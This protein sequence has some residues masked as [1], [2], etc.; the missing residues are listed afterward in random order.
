MKLSTGLINNLRLL[1]K[2]DSIPISRLRML[3][4]EFMS[5]GLL[6]VKAHGSHK[7]IY[8][9]DPAALKI[10]LVSTYPEL[11][12]L[13]YDENIIVGKVADRS[14]Q[15]A[16]TGDSKISRKRSCPG[17]PVN[18]C[19]PVNCMLNDRYITIY[20]PEGSFMFISDWHSFIVPKDVIIVGVENMESF[21]MVRKW[22]Y[23]VDEFNDN[24]PCSF[25]CVYRY[26]NQKDKDKNIGSRDLREW[27]K[28]IPNKYIHFG[29]F[30]LAGINI[31]LSEFYSELGERAQFLIPKDIEKRLAR[32]SG[33][34]YNDHNYPN[35]KSDNP[36][37]QAL[38]DLINKYH[39]GYDQE[40]YN[41]K[42]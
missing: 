1:I 2:G 9:P 5:E 32:G 24:Q 28:S 34:R 36:R 23:L 20:P 8:A 16:A 29:D 14:I 6:S 3:S 38:I 7:I 11:A 41:V 40:G 22:S 37:L 19:A 26:Y 25:L 18:S 39:R 12:D 17:F 4:S 13:N 35:L 31:F 10:Y 33:K 27:L 42:L 30:D 21:R 15:A